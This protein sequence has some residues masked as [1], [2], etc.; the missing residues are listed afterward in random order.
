MPADSPDPATQLRAALRRQL[1][2]R[3]ESADFQRRQRLAR[4]NPD[5]R[6]YWARWQHRGWPQ[7]PR[8]QEQRG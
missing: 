2:G 5:W 6:P 7:P 3:Q 1:A 4:A 8:E